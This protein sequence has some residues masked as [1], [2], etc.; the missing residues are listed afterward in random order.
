MFQMAAEEMAVLWAPNQFF[1]ELFVTYFVHN[2]SATVSYGQKK[3][4]DIRTVITHLRLDNCHDFHRRWL[5]SLFGRCSAVV[6]AGL[7]AAT[8]P[9]FLFVCVCFVYTCVHLVDFRWVY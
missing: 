5:L 3:L 7:L 4:L 9:F 2:V 1:C 6:V 8:N